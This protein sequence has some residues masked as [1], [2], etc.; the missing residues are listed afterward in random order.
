M[1]KS[2]HFLTESCICLWE[3]IRERIKLSISKVQDSNGR[4]NMVGLIN[5]HRKRRQKP[6]N[7]YTD[8][9]QRE[10]GQMIKEEKQK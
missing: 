3:T 6:K 10:N 8:V 7:K 1:T 4:F 9:I 2:S 5:M